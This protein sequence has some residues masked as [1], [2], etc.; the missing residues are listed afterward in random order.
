MPDRVQQLIDKLNSSDKNVVKASIAEEL[1]E[2]GDHRAMKA[3]ITALNN[4]EMQVRWNAIKALARFGDDAVTPLLKEV[5]A[6]DRFKRRNIVQALGELGGDQAVDYLIRM[7]MFD[8]T[9]DAVLIEVIRALDRIRDKRAVEPMIT[10]LKMKNWEMRWRAIHALEHLGDS[11]AIEPLLETINDPDKDI[12]W[13]AYKAIE[14]IKAVIKQHETDGAETPPQPA[15]KTP[16]RARKK[17][18]DLNLSTEDRPDRIVIFIEGELSSANIEQFTGYV[19][20]IL[21]LHIKHVEL[22]MA[23]CGF[24]DSFALSRLNSL[25]KK[26][27]TRN[28]NLILT[29][30]RPNVR[31]V[32]TATKL[33][34][35]FTIH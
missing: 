15:P 31:T 28:L 7:L 25:R 29:G 35:L 32:F 14:S 10:V 19:N 16:P 33:D 6:P 34:Q 11:R 12:Q 17:H 1:G 26:L 21:S 5:N 20:G 9:D 18:I 3:L 13:A 2:I 27:K 23:G 24:L 30:L 22:D 8:E 4:E